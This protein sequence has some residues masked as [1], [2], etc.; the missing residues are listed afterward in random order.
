[1]FALWCLSIALAQT[2]PTLAGAWI[3]SDGTTVRVAD[4]MLLAGELQLAA[5]LLEPPTV[6]GD[7]VLFV[8]RAASG[9]ATEVVLFDGAEQVLHRER[10]SL[11]RPA[12]SD[13]GRLLAFVSGRSGLASVWLVRLSTGELTQVTNVGV[14][15]VPG[16][17]PEGFADPP[18]GP[19]TV[20]ADAVSWTDRGGAE[21]R[22]PVPEVQR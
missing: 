15:R 12:L 21:V 4:G 14:T 11:S 22:I 5:E 17:A 8:R 3:L 10:A 18:P 16:R 2:E 9:P 19:P 1:M 20:T 7:R 13:D 6:R